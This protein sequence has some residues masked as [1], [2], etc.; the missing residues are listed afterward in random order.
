M[1]TDA[2][3]RADLMADPDDSR[4][5]TTRGAR[6]MCPCPACAE[7]RAAIYA[8]RRDRE[9]AQQAARVDRLKAS[10]PK[11]KPRKPPSKPV[12]DVCTVD[13][14]LLPMMGKPSI[15]NEAHACCVCGTPAT[16]KHHIVK[17]SSGKLVRDGREVPKPTVRLCGAGN[18][19][20]C[21]GKAHDGML[22]FRWVESVRRDNRTGEVLV[23]GHWECIETDEP[24]KYQDALA[25]DGWRPL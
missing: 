23:G 21:H 20:G 15:D 10:Y 6:L 8:D 3:H 12:K 18:A 19:S 4:H 9:R 25:M 16:N 1:K 11:P 17:R 5:G 13:A 7:T 22:H 24:T 14:I 2:E